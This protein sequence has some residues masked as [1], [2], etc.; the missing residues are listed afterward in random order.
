MLIDVS[1]IVVNYNTLEMT[2]NCIESVIRFTKRNTYEIILVDNHST[3]GSVEFFAKYPNIRFIPNGENYG[4]GKANNI[5][6][7]EAQG[8]YLFLLNSDTVLFKDIISVFFDYSEANEQKRMACCGCSLLDGN[9]RPALSCGHFPSLMQ[10]FSS[11]GFYRLYRKKYHSKWSTAYLFEEHQPQEVDYIIGA[12]W[13]VKRNIFETLEGFDEDYFMYYEEAD[14]AYR[15]SRKG[16]YSVVLPETGIIHYGGVSTGNF[17]SINKF[18][19]SFKSKCIYFRKN[20]GVY[21]TFVMKIFSLLY[22][23][24]HPVYYKHLVPILHI[25]IKS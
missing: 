16:Y 13:F 15:M 23:F 24:V 7:R 18:K 10:E 1:I 14:L 21:K 20:K 17:F 4:F 22:Y 2:K 8:K 19:L 11:I 3:D 5:G 9:M 6:A 25:I 12:D